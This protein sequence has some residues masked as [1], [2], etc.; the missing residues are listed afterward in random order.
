MAGHPTMKQPKKGG[1]GKATHFHPQNK[2]F[3]RSLSLFTMSSTFPCI[4]HLMWKRKYRMFHC[5]AQKH[6]RTRCCVFDC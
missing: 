2:Y 4:E 6:T 1:E 3:N 5:D